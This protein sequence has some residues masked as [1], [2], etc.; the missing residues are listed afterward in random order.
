M[1]IDSRFTA[2]LAVVGVSLMLACGDPTTPSLVDPSP[3]PAAP[4]QHIA[5]LSFVAFVGSEIVDMVHP[6]QR[7]TLVVAPVCTSTDLPCPRPGRVNWRVS[8]AFCE[9][10]GDNFAPSITVRCLFAGVATIDMLDMDSG[11]TGQGSVFVEPTI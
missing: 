9:L 5:R 4:Q 1:R 7:F 2:F 8:G 10:T 11:A 6:G 3:S